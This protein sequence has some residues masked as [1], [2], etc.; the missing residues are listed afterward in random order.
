MV[1][2]PEFPLDL[3][4]KLGTFYFAMIRDFV[5]LKSSTDKHVVQMPSMREYEQNWVM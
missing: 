3:G 4:G 5:Y 2:S 1:L